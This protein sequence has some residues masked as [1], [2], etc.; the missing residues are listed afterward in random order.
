MKRR[1]KRFIKPSIRRK[2]SAGVK[3]YNRQLKKIQTEHGIERKSAQYTWKTSQ[4]A[5]VDAKQKKFKIL[6]SFAKTI[7]SSVVETPKAE[8]IEEQQR[9][10][11]QERAHK[12]IMHDI[13]VM[14][15]S[16]D[17]R[18]KRELKEA[19][20]IID[21]EKRKE[22]LR[23]IKERHAGRPP[24]VVSL[25]VGEKRDDFYVLHLH[26]KYGIS[27]D[28]A[29]Q[30]HDRISNIRARE[31]KKTGRY[32]TPWP[33][34]YTKKYARQIKKQLKNKTLKLPLKFPACKRDL[35]SRQ[36]KKVKPK[37]KKRKRKRRKKLSHQAKSFQQK[38]KRTRK[39]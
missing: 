4:S 34:V 3:R 25:E 38:G 11:I 10:T 22:K 21:K 29:K 1:H 16:F 36:G 27:I 14:Q 32:D 23:I 2:I 12:K 26:D 5:H 39:K 31:Y 30:E 24:P 15:R 33:K 20:K 9:E 17:R 37:K 13:E 7:I 6:T 8:R 28:E 18:R 35:A 19:K